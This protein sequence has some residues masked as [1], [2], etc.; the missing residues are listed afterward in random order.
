MPSDNSGGHDSRLVLSLEH[1]SKW[2]HRGTSREHQVL[3]DVSLQI[4][5]REV[6]VVIGP[7]GSGKSTLLRCINLLDPPQEGVIRFR[8]REWDATDLATRS[9]LKRWQNG[10]RLRRMRAE[11]GMVFQHFNLF[12]HLTALA[13]VAIG[14]RRALHIPRHEARERARAELDRVGLSDKAGAYPSQLSGGQK[15]RVAIARALAM[16]PKLMMFDEATSALDPEL[17][18][19]ILDEIKGLAETGM[20]MIVVTHEMGFAREV[21]DRIVFMDAGQVI[22]TGPARE[23]IAHPQNPRT[24]AFLQAIL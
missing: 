7:S 14:P 23:L 13:N 12:P 9:P 19:G 2:Y 1:V 20:T 17:V 3:R 10:K 21:G 11:L 5:E 22:E 24:K 8:D 15:Q 18:S 6:L 4:H 16:R